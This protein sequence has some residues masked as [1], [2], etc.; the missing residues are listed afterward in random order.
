MA[1]GINETSIQNLQVVQETFNTKLEQLKRIDE[2]IS[3]K[4]DKSEIVEADDYLI[5]LNKRYQIQ[6]F[7]SSRQS[8]TFS[9]NNTP[10]YSAIQ[11]QG[12]GP[13]AL[14]HVSSRP[15][16]LNTHRLPKLSLPTFNRDSLM[17]GILG[18][19]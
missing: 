2:S 16:S 12:K 10:T 7:I 13:S 14:Q 17:A 15:N 6:F 8:S 5:A 3:S 9:N 1:G 11:N 18:L 4:T 19:I